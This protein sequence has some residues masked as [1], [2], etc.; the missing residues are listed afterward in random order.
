MLKQ[1]LLPVK[2]LDALM[3][4]M[5]ALSTE[6]RVLSGRVQA[7]EDR[8][9]EVEASPIS[10]PF[11]SRPRWRAMCQR[12]PGQDSDVPKEVH[13]HVAKRIRELPT[14]AGATTEGDSTSDE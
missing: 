4:T 11:T 9:W 7:T 14:F 1:G 8:Q 6:I 10:S 5:S 3:R 13:S 2:M 12:S